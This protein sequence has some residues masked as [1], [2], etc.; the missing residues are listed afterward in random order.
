MKKLLLT[1]I[2]FLCLFSPLSAQDYKY[3]YDSIPKHLLK[4]A[5]AVIRSSQCTYAI[6]DAE[7]AIEKH[8]LAV[9]LLNELADHYRMIQIDYSKL[10]RF[11]YVDARVY[12]KYGKIVWTLSKSDI[13]DHSAVSD[14]AIYSD[15]RIKAVSIPAFQYPFTIEYEF[16]VQDNNS[17]FYPTWYFQDDPSVSVEYSG[18][19]ISMPEGYPFRYLE[20][21]L[22]HRIDSITSGKETVLTWQEMNLQA[23]K[24]RPYS[25]P[26]E[27]RMPVLYTA[28]VDFAI[29]KYRGDMTSWKNFGTWTNSLIAD[30]DSLDPETVNKVRSLVS[31]I[32]DPRQKVRKIYEYMQA[33]TRYVAVYIGIGGWQPIPAEEVAKNGYGECKALS[34][35]MK[36]LLKAAGI[37]S[38]Y[39]LVRAGI[40]QD[41]MAEFPSQQFNHVILCVPIE[42]DTIWL[43][44]T[45]Q[46]QPFGYLG[47]FTADRQVLLIT[48]D[49]GEIVRTPA[50][51]TKDNCIV[52]HA[53]IEMVGLGDARITMM[54]DYKGFLYEVLDDLSQQG[55][56]NQ[57]EWIT[58]Y[59]H[60]HDFDIRK[61][62]F[63]F[64]KEIIPSA[65][66]SL[67]LYVRNIAVRTEKRMFIPLQGILSSFD[68]LAD[69]R[70]NIKITQGFTT[71]DSLEIILPVDFD[72]EQLPAPFLYSSAY[73][74]YYSQAVMDKRKLIYTRRVIINEGSYPSEKYE[75]FREFINKVAANDRQRIILT[76]N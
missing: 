6:H 19:Q 11:N 43:E 44:C 71:S 10:S 26:I 50:I 72:I 54:L 29:E 37:E 35:Y 5:N 30:R 13:S 22:N 46:D 61:M 14:A 3:I 55:Q 38:Y 60:V 52:K 20:K 41:I 47:D 33:G 27:M 42:K 34:N 57:K 21:N 67:D 51:A 49:G 76:K 15:D 70:E 16:E 9:T 32:S 25:I 45:D 8:K 68:F 28:P 36:A 31:D 66:A 7:K 74:S 69:Y 59:L 23:L 17:L 40:N 56:H 53:K 12:D 18:I 48:P 4:G 24:V 58:K 65:M 62:N 1:S 2:V 63:R 75:D 39:T 64:D 73:G